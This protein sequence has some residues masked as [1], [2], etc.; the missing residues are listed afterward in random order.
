ML[1]G[2]KRSRQCVP[3]GAVTERVGDGGRAIGTHFWNPPD[4]IPVVE[5]VPSARTAV[6]TTDRV[7]ALLT[8]AGK[9]PVSHAC[10]Y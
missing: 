2:R 5:V 9:L 1:T 3:I 4:L 7:I 6:E 8:Q 10:F